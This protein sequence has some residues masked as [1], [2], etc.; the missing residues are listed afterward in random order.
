MDFLT[1]CL[2]PNLKEQITD[3]AREL[4]ISRSELMRLAAEQILSFDP[5][6]LRD[7][8]TAHSMERKNEL[9]LKTLTER[10]CRF[11]Y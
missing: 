1:I 8:L 3:R 11:D 9:P 5:P 10:S 6:H 4:K 7:N 2:L